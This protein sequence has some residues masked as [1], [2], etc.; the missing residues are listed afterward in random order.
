V[1][2]WGERG[3]CL[4]DLDDAHR[5]PPCADLAW[6][7]CLTAGLQEVRDSVSGW[8]VRE[9]WDEAGIA[10]ILRGYRSAG[11][12]SAALGPRWLKPWLVA[13]MVCAVGDCFLGGPYPV[14]GR[15]VFHRQ[16]RRA[17]E[18]INEI[19]ALQLEISGRT[20]DR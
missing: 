2:L 13:S 11:G 20:K 1:L 4:I 3:G 17:L 10:A 12:P 7:L 15:E 16:L 6:L 9:R 8:R 19:P 5:G 18:R 14:D